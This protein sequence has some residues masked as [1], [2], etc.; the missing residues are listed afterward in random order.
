[1]T[2]AYVSLHPD[3]VPEHLRALPQWVVWRP[4]RR[5][6]DVTKP[7]FKVRDCRH[8]AD[9]TNPTHWATFIEAVAMAQEPAFGLTGI[10]FA[11][12]PENGLVALD[13][14][15][16][17]TERTLAPWARDLCRRLDTYCEYSPSGRGLRLF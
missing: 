5:G 14:D 2:V 12:R 13:L 3:G 10:G 7:P 9:A 16:C 17:I 1:M 11:L 6:D 4:E 15:L 8:Y